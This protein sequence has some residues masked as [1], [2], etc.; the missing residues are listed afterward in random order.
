[1]EPR[2]ITSLVEGDLKKKMVLVA[3]PRQCGKTTMAESILKNWSGA[4]YTWDLD[5]H[6][7]ILRH[8][9]MDAASKLW[10][11][12]ELHKFRNWRN[13]LKGQFDVHRSK[14]AFLVTG[15]ARLDV[16]SRGGDSLQGRYFFYRLHPFTLSELLKTKLPKTLED[17]VQMSTDPGGRGQ[18]T[19][20]DLLAL[21]GFPEPFF[22]G[23]EETAARW[24]LGHG[25]RLIR[26]EIRDLEN[27]RDLDRLELLYD[28]LPAVVG[29]VLSINSLKEDLEVAFETARH[30][31]EIFDR[32]YAS[33][34]LPP[35]GAPRIKAVKKERKLYLWDW[36]RVE[37]EGARFENLVA[38][39]LLRLVHW[40]EDVR[41]EK[42]EL[43]YFRDTLGRE[44]DFVLVRKGK[45]W[46]AVEVKHREQSLDP[47]LKYLLERVAIPYA[48]QIS[49][50]GSNDWRPADICG[51][52]IRILPA[53]R[54]L[55]NLP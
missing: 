7:K 22:S 37:S 35:L 41:G 20:A 39:H 49:L 18:K 8:S 46:M 38:F 55:A 5:A 50:H 36:P 9:Q 30:W 54:F 1:M 51:C 26:E 24:R 29:S 45:P 16:Y 34:R 43:R 27:L 19:L 6:R 10:V 25:T 28:R 33:F 52:Q 12:D 53:A 47:N 44:V 23:S 40:C 3:G 13:W 21:G 14:H 4:Y 15:S 31:L 17:M 11:F 42:M 2:R 48:F 32:L